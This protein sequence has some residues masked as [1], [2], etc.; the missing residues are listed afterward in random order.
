MERSETHDLYDLYQH[1]YIDS[2]AENVKSV[3]KEIVE[4]I[5]E[6]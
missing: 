1:E 2:D 6:H 4:S 5:L 3:I